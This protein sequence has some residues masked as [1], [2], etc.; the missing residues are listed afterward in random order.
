MAVEHSF[1]TKNGFKSWVLSPLKA[2]R[3]K[4]LECSGWQQN[5]VKHCVFPDCALYPFRF[6]KDPGRKSRKY[7]E[8]QK[9]AMAERLKTRR[10][11]N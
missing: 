1:I 6:G 5:E 10:K 8:D 3:Q 11:P 9:R 4:C 2:I 7:T